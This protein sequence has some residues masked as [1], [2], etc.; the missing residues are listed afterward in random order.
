MHYTERKEC[1]IENLQH[2]LD[3]LKANRDQVGE[4]VLKKKYATAYNKL[5]K[6]IR[7]YTAGLLMETYLYASF[8][9]ECTQELNEVGKSFTSKILNEY[10]IQ[11]AIDLA[12]DYL[13]DAMYRGL[14][15]LRFEYNDS[16]RSNVEKIE[17]LLLDCPR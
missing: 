6:E 9:S 15:F 8:R 11:G 14:A 3:V 10:D 7:T 2:K 16:D 4:D 1:L 5:I 17:K 12:Q 13:C